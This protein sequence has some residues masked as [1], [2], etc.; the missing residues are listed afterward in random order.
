MR[1]SVR[2]RGNTYTYVV[3]V[4]Y[5][6]RTGRRRQKSVGGFRTKKEA[7]NALTEALE[8]VRTGTWAD[9]G[10]ITVSES[11]ET[12]LKGMK[13]TIRAKTHESYTSMLTHHVCEHIGMVSG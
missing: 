12:W 7:N 10:S 2:K 8:R 4:G 13:P 11:C 5:D 9:P 3:D 6:E 1:G